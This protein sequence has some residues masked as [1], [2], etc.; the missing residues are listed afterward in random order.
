[1][2]KQ[3]DY[4]HPLLERDADLC[5]MMPYWEKVSDIVEGLSAMRQATTKY[6][7]KFPGELAD[8]YN[9]RLGA[10]K[11]T[12]VYRDVV[13][14][15]STKPFQDEITILG[16]DEVPDEIN[17]FVKDVDGLGNNI[18]MFSALTFFNAINYAIDW[19]L[20]DYPT[21]DNTENI[22]KA[23]A[24]QRNLKPFWSHILAKN[25]LSVKTVRQGSKTIITYFRV[26]EPGEG[27]EPDHV[28][29]F[30]YDEQGNAIWTL[31]QK[32]Q[33]ATGTEDMF[34]VVGRG[35]LTIGIIPIVP[36]VTGRRDGN[37]MKFFPA[38][39]DAAD[40]Q[41]TLYQDE[42]ALQ[43][44][45]TLGAYPMLAANGVKP[46]IG[47]DKK[48]MSVGIGPGRIVYAKPDGSG[49]HGEW[50]FIEPNANSMEFLKKSVDGTK[51]DLRELGRQPLTAQSSQ[52]TTVTT[53]VAAGKAKSAVTAW[54]YGLQDTLENALTLTAMWMKIKGYEPEV[55]VYTGF[56][57][58]LNDGSDLDALVKTRENGD[59]SRETLLDEFKRRKIL[60]PEFKY[61][62]EMEKLF[63]EI[64]SDEPDSPEMDDE[65]DE[66]GEESNNS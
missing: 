15:L 39:E 33:N 56:D 4:T 12:N 45:K 64:P 23:E 58:V 40:L 61:S 47:P 16:G 48:P 31:Y 60:S 55:N 8:D 25:V 51:T 46:E 53:S 26:L 34:V 37:S 32:N 28:R 65:G 63:N 11:L 35:V 3:T 20:I 62:D 6:L 41:I 38:M 10:T 27:N 36:F 44:I 42:S 57:D 14:G 18:T 49:N 43:Y 21:V 2:A 13:E 30:E 52:L 7:P 19:I 5:Y 1:M 66:D 17:E 29:V 9:F 50:K 22:S 24:K 54:A 59:L